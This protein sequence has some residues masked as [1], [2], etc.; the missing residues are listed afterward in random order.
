MQICSRSIWALPTFA[1]N[2]YRRNSTFLILSTAALLLTAMAILHFFF[3]HS[4]LIGSSYVESPSSVGAT[5]R[6]Q[7][8]RDLCLF[9][10]VTKNVRPSL[11][12]PWSLRF[13]F[14][15]IFSSCDRVKVTLLYTFLKNKWPCLHPESSST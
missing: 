13:V 4:H 11:S 3:F 2:Q 8:S 7:S 1:L 10:C 15:L 5:Q 12:R 6:R 9:V 14:R